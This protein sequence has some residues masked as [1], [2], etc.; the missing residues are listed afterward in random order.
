MEVILE[1]RM[2]FNRVMQPVGHLFE[3]ITWR[4]I[5]SCEDKKLIANL[6]SLKGIA[7]FPDISQPRIT[8][9]RTNIGFILVS[10]FEEVDMR[11]KNLIMF[12]V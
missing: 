5:L 6:Q 9:L 2:V 7:L 12:L 1:N 4:H 3:R 11:M 10:P 8:E